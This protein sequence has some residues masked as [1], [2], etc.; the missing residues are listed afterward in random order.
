MLSCECSNDP[1][2]CRIV[3]HIGGVYPTFCQEEGI[4][5]QKYRDRS[6]RCIAI[7][8]KSIGVRDRFDS[9]DYHP[10]QQLVDPA[11]IQTEP[12]NDR[13][14]PE[15]KAAPQQDDERAHQ[16]QSLQLLGC[17][18]EGRRTLPS[19]ALLSHQVT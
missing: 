12:H 1:W 5:L 3:M 11:A 2:P 15:A 6:V 14:V 4:L 9:L 16:S 18:D 13:I 7:L 8:F 19:M 10:T 17:I